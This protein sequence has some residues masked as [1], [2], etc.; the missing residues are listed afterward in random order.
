MWFSK[1]Y[2]IHAGGELLVGAISAEVREESQVFMRRVIIN[3]SLAT[4]LSFRFLF[5]EVVDN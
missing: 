5:K 3:L 2:E 4:I 1:F